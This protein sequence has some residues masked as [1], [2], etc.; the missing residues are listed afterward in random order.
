MIKFAALYGRG[1][2]CSKTI[3]VVTSKITVSVRSC[4]CCCCKWWCLCYSSKHSL[5]QPELW[6]WG[7]LGPIN[8]LICCLT[9]APLEFPTAFCFSGY[10]YKGPGYWSMHVLW[11]IRCYAFLIPSVHLL[12]ICFIFILSWSYMTPEI[13]PAGVIMTSKSK[14]DSKIWKEKLQSENIA[15]PKRNEKDNVHMHFVSDWFRNAK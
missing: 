13:I 6:V 12:K 1:L 14:C 5:V 15:R 3:T 7:T 4:C 11:R 10:K 2:W 8:A 9:A